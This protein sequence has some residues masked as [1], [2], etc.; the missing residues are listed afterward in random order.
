MD[1]HEI[2]WL[3][4]E[5]QSIQG[6]ALASILFCAALV[7]GAWLLNKILKRR[8]IK[9]AMWICCFVLPVLHFVTVLWIVPC[10]QR[11]DDDVVGVLLPRFSG[12]QLEEYLG[13]ER[14]NEVLRLKLNTLVQKWSME[15]G[16][17]LDT[18]IEFRTVSWVANTEEVALNLERKFNA[19]A[20]LWGNAIRLEDAAELTFF[21]ETKYLVWSLPLRDLPPEVRLYFR[22][23]SRGTYPLKFNAPQSNL[24]GFAGQI[25]T[26]LMPLVSASCIYSRPET[27]LAIIRYLPALNSTYLDASYAGF[28]LLSAA[29]AAETLDRFEL[30]RDYYAL[31]HHWLCRQESDPKTGVISP[32]VEDRALNRFRAFAKIKQAEMAYQFGDST[33]VAECLLFLLNDTNYEADLDQWVREAIESAGFRIFEY[34]EIVQ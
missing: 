28:L 21:I 16:L 15:S 30:A 26:K 20:L 25:M 23:C 11:F 3:T 6:L 22:I 4:V 31:S 33:N 14:L 7:S 19:S 10:Y 27:A 17:P 24:N 34:I 1:W 18:M 5:P 8:C 32:P 9:T 12:H 29:D 2:F 13:E